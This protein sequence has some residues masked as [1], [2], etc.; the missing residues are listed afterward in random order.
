MPRALTI[1][2]N[3]WDPEW[4]NGAGKVY[5]LLAEHVPDYDLALVLVNDP[6]YGGTGGAFAVV[7]VHP[8]VPEIVMHEFGHAYAWLGDEYEYSQGCGLDADRDRYEGDEPPVPNLTIE[9]NR[10]LVKWAWLI[11][12]STPLPTTTN[13]NCAIC[14]PQPDPMPAGTVGLYEGGYYYHCGAYRPVYS[15]K[16]R[17]LGVDFCPVCREAIVRSHYERVSP[18][19]SMIPVT[20]ADTIGPSEAETLRVVT[21]TPM[22]H[23]LRIAWYADG[24]P[25]TPAIPATAIIPGNTLGAGTHTV[26]CVVDDTTSLIRND[27]GAPL[28]DSAVWSVTVGCTCACHGDPLCDRVANI[29]DV[30]KTVEVA[31]RGVA[32]VADPA[33]P[34]QRT[35]VNCDG[36]TTVVDVVK[37]VNVA[38]RGA[39]PA[40]EYCE[41]CGP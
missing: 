40:T 29:Q 36:V 21:K 24:S 8:T 33:C 23:A 22:T 25:F 15:C 14:D 41:P 4:S 20:P 32:P 30:V 26:K 28:R 5:T 37:V 3:D 31:F 13:A 1:P 6:T 39:N 19:D 35:D 9:T 7:S 16:M 18:I 34:K 10:A 2:P 12:G 38:F 11:L 27:P 17:R